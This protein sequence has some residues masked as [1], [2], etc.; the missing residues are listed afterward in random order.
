MPDEVLLPAITTDLETLLDA[1]T[2]VG[3]RWQSM[4]DPVDGNLPPI[5]YEFRVMSGEVTRDELFNLSVHE[6]NSLY[7]TVRVGEMVM[8]I[9]C[10]VGTVS[11]YP[12]GS[13]DAVESEREAIRILLQGASWRP[14]WGRL[15][16]WMPLLPA[17]LVVVG[18][19]WYTATGQTHPAVVVAII[20]AAVLLVSF[21][22][23]WSRRIRRENNHA[24]GPIKFRAQSRQDLYASRADR[25]ANFKVA[26][27]TAPVSIAVA[28]FIAWATGFVSSK[29]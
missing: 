3:K 8:Q 10:P 15:K 7:A 6:R 29:P 20:G 24:A 13:S 11:V 14:T 1:L 9:S 16:Q 23:E 4:A 5:T 25:L 26:L 2:V 18:V 12:E 27:I 17:V 28:L 19:V 21:A 22:L